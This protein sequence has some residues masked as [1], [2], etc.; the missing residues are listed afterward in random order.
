M[1][2]VGGAVV[3]DGVLVVGVGV[4]L[5]GRTSGVFDR[6]YGRSMVMHAG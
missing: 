5:P 2:V 6:V 1:I 3:I 4:L